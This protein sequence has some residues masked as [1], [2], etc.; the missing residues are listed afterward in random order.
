MLK[1]LF[2]SCLVQ[3]YKKNEN[4]CL[5]GSSVHQNAIACN[6]RNKVD[7]EWDKYVKASDPWLSVIQ[8]WQ[9]LG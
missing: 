6:M 8:K 7:G 9:Q 5:G 1:W 2:I 4:F 3:N